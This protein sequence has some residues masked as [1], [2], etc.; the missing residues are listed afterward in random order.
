MSK[1]GSSAPLNIPVEEYSTSDGRSKKSPGSCSA[2][3]KP[4]V[5]GPFYVSGEFKYCSQDCRNDHRIARGLPGVPIEGEGDRPKSGSGFPL[6]RKEAVFVP[7]ACPSCGS[8][9]RTK[10]TG[11]ARR[12]ETSGKCPFTGLRYNVV[13]FRNCRC[14]DCGQALSV[15][16]FEWDDEFDQSHR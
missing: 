8:Q 7:V 5:I 12:V 13:V 4:I 6:N 9:K 15:K 2:C 10:F 3:E 14:K 16:S 1:E 11:N